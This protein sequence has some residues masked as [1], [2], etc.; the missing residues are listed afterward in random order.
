MSQNEQEIRNKIRND[1]KSIFTNVFVTSIDLILMILPRA[2]FTMIAL[3]DPTDTNLFNYMCMRFALQT[4][5]SLNFLYLCLNKPF[6]VEL[7]A[8]F[9]RSRGNLSIANT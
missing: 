6:F 2:I 8:I 7:K 5:F 3:A 9:S 1:I 4:F